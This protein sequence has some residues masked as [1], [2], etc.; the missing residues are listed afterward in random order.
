M[1]GTDAQIIGRSIDEPALFEEIFDRHYEIIRGY[2]QRRLGSDDGEEVAASTFEQAFMLRRRFDG[3][4]S[5]SARPWL[6]G[7]ANNLVRSHLRHADVEHR[8]LPVSISPEIFESEPNLDAIDAQR[9]A[10]RLQAALSALSDPDRET[11]LLVV[12]GELAY[13]DVAAIVGV[14]VGTVR[15]RVNRARSS[16]RELLGPPEAINSGEEEQGTPE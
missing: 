6:F 8:H 16:L 14:P 9:Q 3:T 12:L 1:A 15:S 13:A 11:F 10:P 7:I 2:A 4:T 5:T